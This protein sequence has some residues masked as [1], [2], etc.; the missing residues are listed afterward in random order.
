MLDDL[1]NPRLAVYLFLE[2]IAL[3]FALEAVAAFMRGESWRK[4]GGAILIGVVFM[5]LGVKSGAITDRASPRIS[6][7]LRSRAVWMILF[8]ALSLYF[9]QRRTF[10]EVAMTLRQKWEGWIGYAIVG[11]IGAAVLCGYW[12]LTGVVLRPRHDKE[13]PLLQ[14]PPAQSK[15]K[16]HSEIGEEQQQTAGAYAAHDDK[17]PTLVDLFLKT[18]FSYTLRA[19]DADSDAYLIQSSDGYTTRVKRQTYSDFDANTK[20][21]GFYIFAPT[22]G[23]AD[24][25]GQRTVATCMELLKRD[26]V[27]ETFKHF[28]RRVA[29]LS[30]YGDQMTSEHDLRF[31]GRV[32][33]YHEEFLSIPQKA[34]IIKAYEARGMAVTFRGS[35]YLGTQVVAWHH[36]HDAKNKKENQ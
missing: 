25:S 8:T 36:K 35:D 19:T 23:S 22:P 13:R 32:F 4:W 1:P 12:W 15:P 24:I 29:V 6:H 17:P 20:F 26:A 34:D 10:L 3:G 7:Y 9:L 27:Q 5:I 28:A 21:I 16:A 14:A 31:S 11:G 33:I 18:D 30:G 2:M